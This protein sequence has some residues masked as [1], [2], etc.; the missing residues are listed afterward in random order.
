MAASQWK[1]T[2]KRGQAAKD[3]TQSSGTTISGSDAIELNVDRTNMTQ[4]EFEIAMR[5]LVV[6]ALNRLFPAG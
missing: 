4:A 6:A 3:V 2:I 5:E 1:L